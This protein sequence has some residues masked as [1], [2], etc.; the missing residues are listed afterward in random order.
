V[1]NPNVTRKIRTPP[2]MTR[3]EVISFHPLGRKV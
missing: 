1:A 3:H 2:V